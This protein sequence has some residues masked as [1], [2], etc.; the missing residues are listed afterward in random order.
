MRELS[1]FKSTSGKQGRNY[2]TFV[3]TLPLPKGPEVIEQDA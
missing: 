1:G 3:P 2:S